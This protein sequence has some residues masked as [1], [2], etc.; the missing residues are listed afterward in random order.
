[1]LLPILQIIGP[2]PNPFKSAYQGTI[3]SSSFGMILFFN[4]V[5]KLVIVIAGI[6]A[7]IKVLLAGF[8]FISAGGDAKQISNASLQIWQ[9][10]LGLLIVAVSFVLAAVFGWLIFGDPTVILNPKIYGPGT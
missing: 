4:N 8:Q 1:M 9:A 2:I 10:A 5:L 6:F 3:E 7:F